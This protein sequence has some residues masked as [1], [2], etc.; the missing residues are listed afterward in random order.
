MSTRRQVQQ[1]ANQEPEPATVALVPKAY[2]PRPVVPD[3]WEDSRLGSGWVTV[4]SKRGRT[5]P[6]VATV[7][8]ATAVVAA[9]GA[10]LPTAQAVPTAQPAVS[11]E[12]SHWLWAQVAAIVAIWACFVLARHLARGNHQR[13]TTVN[14]L[15]GA[16]V[17]LWTTQVTGWTLPVATLWDIAVRTDIAPF[18]ATTTIALGST[19]AYLWHRAERALFNR[20]LKS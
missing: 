19:F 18:L 6:K 4:T 8:V 2:L 15:A 1:A 13:T 9:A 11:M 17:A 20:A 16:A 12:E 14:R 7:A 5:N 10:M 3:Y